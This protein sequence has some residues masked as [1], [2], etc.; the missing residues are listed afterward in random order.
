VKG[1]GLAAGGDL[2]G[3]GYWYDE[4]QQDTGD[5]WHRTLIDPGLFARIGALAPGTRVL[6]LGCGNGYI[7]RRLARA[8]AKVVGVDRSRELVERARAWGKAERLGIAYHLADAADLR[9]IRDRSFDLGIANMS[10]MDIA[11]GA[12]AIREMARVLVPRGRFIFSIS[13]PCFDI[14]T[15][16]A[17]VLEGSSVTGAVFRKVTAYREPHEDRYAWNL[18]DGRTAFTSGH[19]R[20]LSWYAKELRRN[21]FVIVDL[22]EPSPGPDYGTQ[23]VRRE[24]LEQIPLHLVVE[25]R[26]EPS[27]GTS[28]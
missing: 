27:P 28:P 20:P 1:N 16:S 26:R 22:E 5:L 23:S 13:H 14:D 4:K 3:F 2:E 19:H 15:R 7:A 8:G 24:W 6:D 10:L 11:D 18:K 21:G 12:G 9:M 17:W 25:A